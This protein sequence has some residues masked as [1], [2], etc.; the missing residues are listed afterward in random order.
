MGK[1]LAE[2]HTQERC[3]FTGLYGRIFDIYIGTTSKY[4]ILS[5]GKNNN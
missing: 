1:G 4:A 5:E 2:G 3:S